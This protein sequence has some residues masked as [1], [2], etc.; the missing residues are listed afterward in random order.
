MH[1]KNGS[2][3]LI[4]KIEEKKQLNVLFLLDNTEIIID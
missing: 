2:I 1:V 4:S 3:D